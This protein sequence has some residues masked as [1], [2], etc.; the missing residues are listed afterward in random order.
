MKAHVCACVW[1]NNK[2]G[3]NVAKD[4]WQFLLPPQ[5]CQTALSAL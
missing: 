4:R 2:K 5:L 1:S 3:D